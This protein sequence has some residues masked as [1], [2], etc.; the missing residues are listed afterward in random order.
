MASI[1]ML[2]PLG[3]DV[4]IFFKALMLGL[5]AFIIIYTPLFRASMRYFFKKKRVIKFMLI[6]TR[7]YWD[8]K[9]LIIKALY[10]SLLFHMLI[11]A[12]HITIGKA[13]GIEIPL[14]YYFIVYPMSAMAGFLPVSFNGIGPRE[15][16]YILFFSL[17]GVKS[18]A[19]LVFGIYWF[20]I[21]LL[22]SLIGGIFYIK[23]RHTPPPEDFEIEEADMSDESVIE[24]Q[25][26]LDP[27]QNKA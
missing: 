27:V 21:V 22:S 23:G 4:P 19:A 9:R 17:V 1:A 24:Q 20:G 11:I 26:E 6:D 25:P 8:N 16:A 2:T 18:S 12:I 13:M 15:G 14:A 5:S 3:K 7:V 10:W